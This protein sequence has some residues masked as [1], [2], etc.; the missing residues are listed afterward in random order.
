VVYFDLRSRRRFLDKTGRTGS[1]T[2]LVNGVFLL[3]TF[4][5]VRLVYGGLLV[6]FCLFWVVV[7]RC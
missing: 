5:G 7:M 6:R 3:V 2:Q 1:T 4:L